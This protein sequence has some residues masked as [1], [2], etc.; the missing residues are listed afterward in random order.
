M[1]IFTLNLAFNEMSESQWKV[2][3]KQYKNRYVKKRELL[4]ELAV[5]QL[6]EKSGDELDKMS[7]LA[8]Q[9]AL[10]KFVF[11]GPV[12]MGLDGDIAAV[13]VYFYPRE[14]FREYKKLRGL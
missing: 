14:V 12:E 4:P 13:E 5:M 11:C 1:P 6:L 10:W 8:G 7:R 9:R 3:I 2:F